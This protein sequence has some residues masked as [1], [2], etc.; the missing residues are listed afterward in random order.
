MVLTLTEALETGRL[1][2]FIAQAKAGGLGPAGGAQFDDAI[3]A[4]VISYKSRG[5]T[6]SSSASGGSGGK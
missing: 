4:A 6:S 3:S 1:P 5:Q 2:D